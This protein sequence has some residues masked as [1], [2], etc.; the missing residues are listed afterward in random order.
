MCFEIV[1]DVEHFK[2]NA[3]IRQRAIN[4]YYENP[5]VC[6][7]CGEIIKIP[8]NGIIFEIKSKK[9]CNSA[10]ANTFLSIKRKEVRKY[11]Y[12]CTDCGCVLKRRKLRCNECNE[13]ISPKY[14][15]I[16]DALYHKHHKASGF[17]YIRWNARSKLLKNREYLCEYCGYS[18]IVECCHLKP[19]TS[20]SLDT[21]I[22]EVNDLDNL[23]FM[24][25]NHHWE[26]EHLGLKFEEIMSSEYYHK[27]R[28]RI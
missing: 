14:E 13:K 12:R 5:G 1:K 24:C 3:R 27:N 26:M 22:E 18:K 16:K 2:G 21:K 25:P 28:R 9:F 17:A 10:C 15:T 4:K 7:N 23:L 8:C 20:F 6:I 11:K 19:I